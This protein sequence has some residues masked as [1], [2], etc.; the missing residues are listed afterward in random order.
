MTIEERC[1]VTKDG[2]LEVSIKAPSIKVQ[3]IQK[4]GKVDLA[5]KETRSLIHMTC[6]TEGWCSWA[7]LSQNL[8]GT[9]TELPPMNLLYPYKKKGSV[10]EIEQAKASFDTKTWTLTKQWAEIGTKTTKCKGFIKDLRPSMLVFT[11]SPR[12]DNIRHW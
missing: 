9:P 12:R 4:N 2:G 6:N 5:F 1:V 7:E 8:D 10:Y 11:A 3:F